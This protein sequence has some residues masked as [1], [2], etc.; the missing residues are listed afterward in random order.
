[1]KRLTLLAAL[2][3]LAAPAAA[4]RTP[5]EVDHVFV[6]VEPGASGAFDALRAA[7]FAVDTGTTRHTGQGTAS[8]SVLFQ[9]VYL[10]LIWIDSTVSV[11]GEA[12]EL[13][14]G[15]RLAAA[16]R[17][18]GASPFGIGLRA[19]DHTRNY[20]VEEDPYT[21]AWMER[22]SAIDMLVQDG[23]RGAF[24]LFVV[25]GYMALPGWIDQVRTHAAWLLEHP[26]GVRRVT[27]ATVYGAASHRPRAATTLTIPAFAFTPADEP[28][29]V[30]DVVGGAAGTVVD[31]RPHAPVLIRRP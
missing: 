31:L 29:L 21:A 11:E 20:G 28:L 6:V 8:R 27:H 7:G 24:E 15:M 12:L 17:E 5:V 2:A 10:E 26:N 14:E 16:W 19:L 25:P 23:E 18:S 4:Q 9:N 1:M 3:M 30:L 13:L 22:G